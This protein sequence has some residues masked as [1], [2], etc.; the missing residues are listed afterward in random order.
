MNIFWSL[1]RYKAHVDCTR[2]IPLR[3]NLIL[4]ESVAE[5]KERKSRVESL[6]RMRLFRPPQ[7]VE[8][9]K[10]CALNEEPYRKE[11]KRFSICWRRERPSIL[12]CFYEHPRTLNLVG[13]YRRAGL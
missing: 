9:T 3:S 6:K 4:L 1:F 5:C 11:N 10:H 2:E 13:G 12:C 8:G 7:I